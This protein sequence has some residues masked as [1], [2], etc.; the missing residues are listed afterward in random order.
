MDSSRNLRRSLAVKK[1]ILL[2]EDNK[3]QKLANERI[4]VKAGYAVLSA[5]DGEQ[6][7]CVAQTKI[8]DL[9]LLDMLLPKMGGLG[10]LQALKQHP[11]TAA[12]PVIAL[13][14][15]PQANSAKLRGEGAADYFE[16]S[17]LLEN[18]EGEETFLEILARVLQES[19]KKNTAV[20]SASAPGNRR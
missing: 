20:M 10:V 15:L 17:R 3:I 14:G 4:L 8:P 16:K 11:A 1:T 18:R 7:L 19:E 2:V 9:I 5:A 12:I 6:A 13:S